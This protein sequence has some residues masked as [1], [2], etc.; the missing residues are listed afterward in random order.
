M[1]KKTGDF[2]RIW[3]PPV[4]DKADNAAL[5]VFYFSLISVGSMLTVMQFFCF[6]IT[7]LTNCLISS[8]EI[9]L[10]VSS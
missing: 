4:S 2:L 8:D 9:P 10:T 5:H 3:K 1:V 7:P 6:S